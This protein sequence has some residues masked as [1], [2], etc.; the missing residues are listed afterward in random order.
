MKVPVAETFLTAAATSVF[1]ES[2]YPPSWP[3][4][5]CQPL[6]IISARE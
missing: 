3:F 1:L 4:A 5:N 6:P 2:G